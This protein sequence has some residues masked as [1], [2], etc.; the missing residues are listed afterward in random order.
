MPV[1]GGIPDIDDGPPPMPPKATDPPKKEVK[2]AAGAGVS[3]ESETSEV[4]NPCP[5]GS[6]LNP[7]T[8]ICDTG[9]D[10]GRGW[11]SMYRAVFGLCLGV[12]VIFLGF[13][14]RTWLASKTVGLDTADKRWQRSTAHHDEER[15]GLVSSMD[16]FD[17]DM[18]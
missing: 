8:G 12:V 13:L 11:V 2:V 5:V 18:L 9:D 14:M 4:L 17:D 7:D 6:T 16:D 3:A 1:S 10:D 15:K